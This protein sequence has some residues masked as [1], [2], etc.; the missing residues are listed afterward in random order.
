MPFATTT[1]ATPSNSYLGAFWSG[2]GWCQEYPTPYDAAKIS[3]D[4]GNNHLEIISVTCSLF[5]SSANTDATAE[6]FFQPS[7]SARNFPSTGNRASVG[8]LT[9]TST[10]SRETGTFATPIKIAVA[11]ASEVR[12]FGFRITSNN[13]FNQGYDAT[14][15]SSNSY[16]CFIVSSGNVA[17]NTDTNQSQTLKWGSGS[18][19][20]EANANLYGQIVYNTLPTAPSAPTAG[21]V[22]STTI[23]LSCAVSGDDGMGGGAAG[24]DITKY[25]V[26]NV[27][28]STEE[29]ITKTSTPQTISRTG[30]TPNTNYTFQLALESTASARATTATTGPFSASS[31]TIRTKLANPT[32]TGSYTAT[33]SVGVSYTSAVTF[34]Q[35]IGGGAASLD[36]SESVFSGELPPGLSLVAGAPTTAA[37]GLSIDFAI[38]GT[39]TTAGSYTFTIR[40]TNGDGGTVTTTS[41]TITI[42]AGTVLTP[43]VNTSLT[44]TPNFERSTLKVNNGSTFVP[45][46]MKVHNGTDWT[47]LS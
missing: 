18:V 1:V 12:G 4:T 32:T 7:T 27:T 47:D 36:L 8:T 35:A 24:T 21:T 33:G 38:T 3:P 19:Y 20:W 44:S 37:E 16:D 10:S 40:A 14:G 2:W 42:E 15:S 13:Y 34:S 25:R 46:T 43:K 23:D 39:P 29:F 28:T 45:G 30:L 22:T 26:K 17:Y 5:N 11:S 9:G 31:S 41:Q 6:V